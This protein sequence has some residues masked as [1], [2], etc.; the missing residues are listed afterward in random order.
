[1]RCVPVPRLVVLAALLMCMPAVGF[2]Q[3]A[4][5]SSGSSSTG[6]VVF[7]S[8]EGTVHRPG[9]DRP[10]VEG[11]GLVEGDTLLLAPESKASGFDPSGERFELQGPAQMVFASP[12]A[13]GTLSSVSS[14]VRGQL[15]EWMGEG[16]QQALTMRSGRSWEITDP[17]PS[18][19][20]PAV[21][22]R[23]RP[24]RSRFV[25]S[26][27]SG[28][29]R[30][31]VTFA[32]AKGEEVSRSVRGSDTVIED[33]V[34]GS[35]YVWKVSP[36]VEN[37][38]GQSSWRSFTVMSREEEQKLDQALR[39]L[40]DLDAGVLLLSAGLHAEAVERLDV[41]ARSADR[42]RSARLWRARA[43]AEMGLYKEACADLM[44]AWQQ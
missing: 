6:V 9:G 28:I 17:V 30:Y 23:V 20:L 15:R 13:Q 32:P 40:D 25:W 36:A 43:L 7:A 35:E 29:D 42:A 24:A 14:W 33:L 3:D 26:S 44:E 41:A 11:L 39:G 21:K 27:V 4:A 34:P 1:M 31:E 19:I 2:A 37:W 10:V 12:P 22:G 5:G 18:Q 38:Q 8:G 16:R